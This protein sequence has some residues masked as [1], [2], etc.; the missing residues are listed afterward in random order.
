MIYEISFLP[1]VEEDVLNT[2][3]WY[4]KKAL[5]LGEEFLRIFYFSI[6]NISNNPLVY[7]KVYNNFHRCLFKRFPYVI[8]FSVINKTI[9]IFGVFHCARNPSIVK[10]IIKNRKS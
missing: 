7:Q 1:E 3:L 9:V 2:Y 6:G 10:K 4:E 8:Y 5:G